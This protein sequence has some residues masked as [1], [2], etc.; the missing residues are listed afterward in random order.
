MVTIAVR[1]HAHAG[2]NRFALFRVVSQPRQPRSHS[3]GIVPGFVYLPIEENNSMSK[4][5]ST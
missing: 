2:S 3:H 1:G 5:F 4:R